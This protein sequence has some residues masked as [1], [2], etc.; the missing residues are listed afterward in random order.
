MAYFNKPF[1]HVYFKKCH[2][3]SFSHPDYT[4]GFGFAPNPAHNEL[5]GLEVLLHHR[6]LGIS[7]D[8]EGLLVQQYLL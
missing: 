1:E 3:S 5:T 6:R 7:P 2:Y 4:V 8:P